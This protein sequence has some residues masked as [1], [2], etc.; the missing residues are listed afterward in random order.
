MYLTVGVI[1]NQSNVLLFS[2]QY[3]Y[4]APGTPG[5]AIDCTQPITF[6]NPVLQS[7]VSDGSPYAHPATI[8]ITPIF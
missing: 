3:Q 6:A 5:V 7:S 1:K 4:S 8:T 2:A